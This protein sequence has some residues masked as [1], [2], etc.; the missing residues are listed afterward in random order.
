MKRIAGL[1]AVMVA[2]AVAVAACG[3]NSNSNSS[4]GGS[5]TDTSA[6]TTA[7]A[8]AAS[9]GSSAAASLPIPLAKLPSMKVAAGDVANGSKLFAA[10]CESCHG[11]GGKNGQVGPTLAGTGLK[12]GQVAFM[13]RNPAAVDK[14]SAMPKLGGITDKDLADISAYVASLKK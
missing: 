12:A 14:D 13:V 1:L 6:P 9:G 5:S 8:T 11:A 10:N 4:S 3:S 2:S 7:A